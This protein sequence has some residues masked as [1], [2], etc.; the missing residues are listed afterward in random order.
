MHKIIFATRNKNK[1]KEIN[2]INSDIAF[3]SLDDVNITDDIPETG[4]T[5]EENAHQKAD[6][7]FARTNT[8]VL[9]E[10]SGLV[11]PSLHG[12]PGINSARYAG[13]ERD[14]K[15]NIQKLLVELS[16]S[17]KRAA[18]FITVI[19]FIDNAGNVH[20]FMGT[21][22][23]SIQHELTGDGGFGY[24]PVFIPNGMTK[25][26]A[27]CTTEEKNA[28]SHRKKAFAKFQLYLAQH[29]DAIE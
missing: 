7:V 19:C 27:E 9:A 15:K 2:S 16:N 1:V 8:S 23:G 20:Y 25:S 29:G 13:P 26:F 18:Y 21:C 11:V 17:E 22:H 24:D 3:I 10:D 28:V 5:F 6:F 4:T 14:D 12:D